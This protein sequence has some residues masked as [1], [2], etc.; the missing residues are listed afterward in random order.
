MSLE[1]TFTLKASV[2]V[3]CR[4]CNESQELDLKTVEGCEEEIYGLLKEAAEI[5]LEN[6]S[7]HDDVCAS[8]RKTHSQQL[9]DEHTADD[10]PFYP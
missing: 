6:S 5:S 3:Y 4:F 2:R 8:C 9:L 7:W 1:P 10:E